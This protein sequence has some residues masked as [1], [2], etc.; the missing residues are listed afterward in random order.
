[1]DSLLK[2]IGAYKMMIDNSPPLKLE[3]AKELDSYFRVETTFSSNA[4]EGNILTLNETKVILEDGITIGGK[5]IK[6]YYEATGHAKAYD[7]LLT[8]STF[9]GVCFLRSISDASTER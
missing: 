5:P 7:S 8:P 9:L 1:M 2:R 3:E 6:D 4:L